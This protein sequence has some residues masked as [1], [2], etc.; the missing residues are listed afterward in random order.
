MTIL[1]TG[2]S[3]F[4]GAAF[5]KKLQRE[6]SDVRALS[7]AFEMSK[8][9]NFATA[10][11]GI[12]TVVHLAAR[13]HVMQDAHAD[14]LAAYRAVNVEGTLNLARQAAVAGVTRF[15]FVSSVKVNGERTEVGQAFTEA[16]IPKPQDA[17]GI[18]KH[19][20]ELGLREL[21]ADT[22]MQIVIV[23]PPLVYGSG[24]R[25][26]FAS[27]M[28]VVQRGW[29]LPLASVK[30]K[31][32]LVALDNLVDFLLL[33][34]SAPQAA[35]QT[36]M[37]SD[38]CDVSTPELIRHMARAIGVKAHLFPI[39]VAVLKV[40]SK[41]IGKTAAVQRVCESLQ[42]DISKAKNLLGWTP[43]VPFEE[44]L[45]QAAAVCRDDEKSL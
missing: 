41:L 7:R 31:R 1:L 25:A 30:N 14:P 45:R 33:C 16:D 34:T 37:V 35:N 28:T 42:V 18:S 29:P 12:G 3:G 15:V 39:S 36:F 2:A 32:S 22:G 44:G 8:E 24:V 23:R 26:N 9:T 13:A 20:A 27:L 5:L 38:G 6:G 17:Y 21:A 43:P 11:D 10:L 19:E 40:V 4:V